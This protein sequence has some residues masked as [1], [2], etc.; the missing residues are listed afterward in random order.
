VG[1]SPNITDKISLLCEERVGSQKWS[2]LGENGHILMGKASKL[3][4]LESRVVGIKADTCNSFRI[5]IER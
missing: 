5:E 1:K 2:L 3:G 4:I